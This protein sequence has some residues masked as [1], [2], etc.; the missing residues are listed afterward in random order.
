MSKLEADVHVRLPKQL[1]EQLKELAE[2][3]DRT[4]GAEIRRALKAWVE[5][6][7]KGSYGRS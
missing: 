7:G 2:E 6:S 3:Q 4:I 1:Y 5:V